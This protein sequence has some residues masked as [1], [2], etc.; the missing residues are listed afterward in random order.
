MKNQLYLSLKKVN[1]NSCFGL[2]FIVLINIFYASNGWEYH[3]TILNGLIMFAFLFGFMDILMHYELLY[4][5]FLKHRNLTVLFSILIFTTLIKFILNQDTRLIVSVMAILIAIYIPLY[6][7]FHITFFTQV[8]TFII[9]YFFGGY[10]H[11]NY[12]SVHFGTIM[13]IYLIISYKIN[14]F[15]VKYSLVLLILGYFLSKS[16]AFLICC[17]LAILL[18]YSLKLKLKYSLIKLKIVEYYFP[19]MILLTVILGLA[20]MSYANDYI[21]FGILRTFTPKFLC[22]LFASILRLI[23]KVFTGRISLG[24]YS[25]Y[26]FGVS[27]FGGN[28]DYSVNIGLKYFVVDSGL[29]LLL[30]D[31]G[32]IITILMSVIFIMLMRMLMKNK[33]YA[34]IVYLLIIILW[35][36]NEDIFISVGSNLEEDILM[37]MNRNRGVKNEYLFI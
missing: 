35:S 14:Q 17:G 33:E 15:N 8:V 19:F 13:L 24:G 16:G 6:K 27:L 11:L 37:L 20:Y 9:C 36:F 29:L 3:G 25:L 7:I 31:W 34:L 2:I 30:Q 1:N 22:N 21:N 28:I 10:T 23:D 26:Y 32:L 5:I 4:K 18:F 12:I